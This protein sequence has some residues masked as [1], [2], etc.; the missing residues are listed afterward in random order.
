MISIFTIGTFTLILNLFLISDLR[1]KVFT[2]TAY[3]SCEKCC[4]KDPSD[5]WYGITA[6]GTKAKWETVDVDRKV[7]KL[8][9]KLRIDRFPNTTFMAEDG[10]GAI[11]GN[12]LDI[13]FPSH[14]EDI[15]DIRNHTLLGFPLGTTS[16]DAKP[17]K[18]VGRI[19][20]VLSKNKLKKR[21]VRL[22][23]ALSRGRPKK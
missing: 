15:N 23:S 3:C 7:I 8:G 22:L 6:T 9:H 12:R 21:T 20:S 19:I 2:T 18:K 13:W 17:D 1:A 4:D 14:E 10:G 5:E 16:S 11:K